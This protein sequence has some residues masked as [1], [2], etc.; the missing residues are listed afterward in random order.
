MLASHHQSLGLRGQ[1]GQSLVVCPTTLGGHWL[2]EITKWVNIQHLNPF[3]YFG[4]PSARASLRGEG[5]ITPRAHKATAQHSKVTA[6]TAAS[7]ETPQGS[8]LCSLQ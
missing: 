7:S 6:S 5:G 1:T 4:H 3:L 2:E 8:S